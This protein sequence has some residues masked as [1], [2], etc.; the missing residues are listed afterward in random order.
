MRSRSLEEIHMFTSRS[1]CLLGQPRHVAGAAV[2]AI[3][4]MENR[5]LLSASASAVDSQA[6]WSGGATGDMAATA[7]QVSYSGQMTFKQYPG[8]PARE[9]R[10]LILSVSPAADGRISGVIAG[11]GFASDIQFNG[12]LE[13]G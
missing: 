6:V 2:A 3:E 1:R 7:D 9:P 13:T 12:Q 5:C 4:T 8:Q 10:D 11:E